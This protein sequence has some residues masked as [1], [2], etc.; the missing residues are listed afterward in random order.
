MGTKELKARLIKKI[1]TADENE[2]KQ[3]EALLNSIEKEEG[4]WFGDLPTP[5][6][7]LLKKSIKQF[8]DG[9]TYSHEEVREMTR[10]RYGLK[11]V[12]DSANPPQEIKDLLEIAKEQAA[13][14]QIRTNEEVKELIKEKYGFPLK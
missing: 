4:D 14:G 2:L 9:Q 5:I 1:E 13:N 12:L 8:E 11:D 6:Q 10:E 3:L 7:E